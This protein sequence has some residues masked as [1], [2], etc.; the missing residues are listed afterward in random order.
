MPQYTV[1]KDDPPKNQSAKDFAKTI[2][3]TPDDFIT[4]LLQG[5]EKYRKGEI[6]PEESKI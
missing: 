4:L 5:V 6:Q 2:G 3:T 1:V